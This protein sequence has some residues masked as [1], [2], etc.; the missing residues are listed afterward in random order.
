MTNPVWGNGRPEL[1]N[2]PQPPAEGQ[3]LVLRAQD[4]PKPF[5]RFQGPARMAL[6]AQSD[7]GKVCLV[8]RYRGSGDHSYPEVADDDLPVRKFVPLAVFL[9]RKGWGFTGRS[10]TDFTKHRSFYFDR[11][12]GSLDPEPIPEEYAPIDLQ[13]IPAFLERTQ[14]RLSSAYDR[15]TCAMKTYAEADEHSPQLELQDTP[16]AMTLRERYAAAVL[17]RRE[18]AYGK[19]D[20]VIPSIE[21]GTVDAVTEDHKAR[22]LLEYKTRR[23][24]GT[25]RPTWVVG[26]PYGASLRVLCLREDALIPEAKKVLHALVRCLTTSC[27]DQC[28]ETDR[29]LLAAEMKLA[30][31]GYRVEYPRSR[32]W[33]FGTKPQY[34]SYGEPQRAD[35]YF[36]PPR[37]HTGAVA[38]KIELYPRDLRGWTPAEKHTIVARVRDLDRL[39]SH[40]A[41]PGTHP[42]EVRR[43]RDEIMKRERD[44]SP[45]VRM[46]VVDG[47]GGRPA[48]LEW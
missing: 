22:K 15:A 41:V 40:I 24:E 29:Q 35:G 2:S 45:F 1:Y 4:V 36:P 33:L 46:V 8:F 12:V 13:T 27:S 9:S 37:H 38:S 26:L 11:I 17:A 10:I 34:Y 48:V 23:E 6:Q 18:L 14:P 5:S 30:D 28:G 21:S 7:I 25:D 43:V 42:A 31:L 3:K 32:E 44:L 19:Q 20:P 39:R 16:S 47:G